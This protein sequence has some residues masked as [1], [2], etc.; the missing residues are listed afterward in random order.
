MTAQIPTPATLAQRFIAAL[1]AQQFTASDGTAVTL[2]ATAPAT[3]ESALAIL[4]G[5]SDYE[6]YLYL[7][8]QLLELMVTT[9]TITPGTGLLPE[10]AKIWNVPRIGATAAVGYF[11]LSSTASAAVTVPA[12]TTITVDGTVQ[13]TT[14]SA[15]TI[16][17]GATASVAVTATVTGVAGNLAANTAGVLVWPV[18][19][20]GSVVTDQNGLAGGAEIEAVESWRARIIDEIRNPDAGGTAANYEKWAKAA[21]ATTVNVVPGWMGRGSVGVIVALT[22]GVTPTAAQVAAVQAYIDTKRPV[23]GN[24]TVFGAVTVA[25]D[26]TLVLNPDTQSARAAVV[27]ALT[28]YYLGLSIGATIYREG[29]DATI[30]AVAGTQNTLLLPSG[31]VALAVNQQAILGTINWT[32]PS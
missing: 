27:N 12:G 24:V 7:R 16:A 32:A 18:A 2:D 29:V 28:T 1:G 21:G 6:T 13:W 5:L 10:H 8:D 26:L 22:R 14:N 4:S 23:R 3:L 11:L 9:A 15:I 31:N 19:G 25:Q 17:A 30:T 20:I